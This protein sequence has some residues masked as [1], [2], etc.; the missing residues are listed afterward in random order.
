MNHPSYVLHGLDVLIPPKKSCTLKILDLSFMAVKRTTP[1]SGSL[2]VLPRF[3]SNLA[4][5]PLR[6]NGAVSAQSN[7]RPNSL[8]R[9][10]T[11]AKPK[12]S[13][14][15]KTIDGYHKAKQRDAV[16]M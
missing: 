13:K 4:D 16:F 11:G 3:Y 10:V 12:R 7:S 14:D 2:N 6:N 15:T 9:V 1:L 8:P 5:V